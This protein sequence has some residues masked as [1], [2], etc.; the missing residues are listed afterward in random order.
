MGPHALA[1]RTGIP[2]RSALAG[3]LLQQF[4]GPRNVSASVL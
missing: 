1:A 2:L 3:L 4:H